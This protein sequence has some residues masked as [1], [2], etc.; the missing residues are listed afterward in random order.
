MLDSP[1]ESA[2]LS[3]SKSEDKLPSNEHRG[4]DGCDSVSSEEEKESNISK[5]FEQVNNQREQYLIL[6]VHGIGTKEEYQ[7]QNVKEFNESIQKV[8][9]RNFKNSDY[10]FVIKMV[11][12]KSILNNKQTKEKVDRVTVVEGA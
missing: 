11:D 5:Q 12:W 10:E 6:L 1:R 9:R 7:A 3:K 2:L 4:D 8:C